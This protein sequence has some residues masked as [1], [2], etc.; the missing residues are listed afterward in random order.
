MILNGKKFVSPPGGDLTIK[1]VLDYAAATGAGIPVGGDGFAEGPWTPCLLADAI[2]RIEANRGSLDLRTVQNW[3]QD[4]D[5]GI[6][7]ANIRWL[8]RVFGCGDQDATLQWQAA[9]SAGQAKLTAKRRKERSTANPKAP[10]KQDLEQCSPADTEPQA[11][12]PLEK[13]GG[14]NLAEKSEAMFSA[15]NSLNL[16]IAVWATCGV[17]WFSTYILGVHSITYSPTE[18]LEKQV[19][20]YWSIS[21]TIGEMAML[22]LFLIVVADLLSFW[23]AEGRPSLVAYAGREPD[24]HGWS[25]KVESFSFSYWAILSICFLGIFLLQWWGVYLR[26]LLEGDP[27]R[28]MLDWIRVVLVRPDIATVPEVIVVS[29]LGFFYSGLIYWFFFVGLLL[30]YKIVNDLSDLFG[31][32]SFISTD[33]ERETVAKATEKVMSGVFRCATL[34]V[35]LAISLKLNAA[36]LVSDGENILSWLIG[37]AMVALGMND[38]RWNWLNQSPSPFFTSFLLLFITCFVFGVCF[39]CIYGVLGRSDARD[40]ESGAGPTRQMGTGALKPAWAR[41]VSV[42]VLLS[43]NYFM[44]GQFYGFSLVL[45]IS[46]IIGSYG[47]FAKCSG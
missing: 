32:R 43:A 45:L 13:P 34:G 38:H 21:W 37:D 25:K 20:F 14:F 3:F 23:K 1:E 4:N 35:L 28:A 31:S 41:M 15:K 10:P 2:S 16:P 9:L 17:L 44:I 5:K 40:I 27:G 39:A 29:L 36:Y 47:V 22:P 7:A 26:P 33:A 8:A 19:G 18:G 24:P 11:P 30:L 46:L 42:M 12:F 6:C